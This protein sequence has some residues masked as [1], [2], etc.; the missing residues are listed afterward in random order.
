MS[1]NGVPAGTPTYTT[2]F[3]RNN[4]ATRDFQHVGH[5]VWI[6]GLPARGTNPRRAVAG[7]GA[8]LW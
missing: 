5:G 7:P 2:A 8:E 4:S 6:D 3:V 1:T